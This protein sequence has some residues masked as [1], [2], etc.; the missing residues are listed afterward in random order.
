MLGVGRGGGGGGGAGGVRM[1]G[2]GEG[3]GD[4]WPNKIATRLLAT[5]ALNGPPRTRSN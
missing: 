1:R 3:E 2:G 4:L 5:C